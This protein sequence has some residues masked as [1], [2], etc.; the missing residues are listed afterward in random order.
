MLVQRALS[1]HSFI[2]KVITQ[3]RGT[4]ITP[5]A[6]NSWASKLLLFKGGEEK[7]TKQKKTRLLRGFA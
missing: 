6:V 2:L 7:K 3:S 5:N 4:I 1:K